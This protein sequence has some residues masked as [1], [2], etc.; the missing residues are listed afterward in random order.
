M[1]VTTKKNKRLLPSLLIV[2]IA[3]LGFL[4]LEQ[5]SS[6]T[7]TVETFRDGQT[8]TRQFESLAEA[9]AYME[10]GE[11]RA[12]IGPDGEVID[13]T[14]AGIAVT[15][16]DSITYL[17]KDEALSERQS[18]VAGGTRLRLLERGHDH[19]RVNIS[20]AVVFVPLANMTLYPDAL[21]KKRGFYEVRDG[22][23]YHTVEANDNLAGTFLVG[24]ADEERSDRFYTENVRD[25][26]ASPYQFASIAST[27]PYSASELDRFLETR[28]DSPLIGKGAAFK[29]AES[30]HGIN[31]LFLLA[32]AGH[33]SSYG[34]SAIARD[35]F[36]LFGF[37]ATDDDPSGNA[38]TFA[39]FEASVDAAARLFAEK[40]VTGSYAR[41]PF[42]GNKQE[43]INIFYASDPYWGEKVA[44]TMYLIDRTLGSAYYEQIK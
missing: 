26:F 1:K 40:Y 21:V 19:L 17:F 36:N 29:D 43:G 13:F 15:P 28:S 18:Y 9:R 42:P 2:L 22:D 41:G 16:T 34:T 4:W 32:V 33:E 38:A 3:V 12:L 7:Y 30:K 44:G 20:G 24:P 11:H 10:R 25:V 5:H 6:G 8:E 31:A 37:K 39:S 35:K 23:V 27:S 14:G